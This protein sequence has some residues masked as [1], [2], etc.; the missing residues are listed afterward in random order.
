MMRG[1]DVRVM[2]L[3]NP[4]HKIEDVRINV[5]YRTTVIIPAEKAAVSKDLWRSI[6]QRSLFQLPSA[7]PPPV[8]KAGQTTASVQD[9]EAIQS[10]LA[11]LEDRNTKLAAE[12]QLLRTQLAES[13]EKQQG[14]LEAI[15]T[16]LK[17]NPQVRYTQA[18]NGAV[19]ATELADGAAPNFIPEVIKPGDAEA[20][21][22][23]RQEEAVSDVSSVADKLKKMRQGQ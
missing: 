11:S 4:F 14:T 21:I 22:E 19:G 5:A 20:R 16:Q 8:S 17:T 6:S 15:L 7:A 1:G 13:Q 9:T 10:R 3:V 12:S 2:G 23:S 18:G